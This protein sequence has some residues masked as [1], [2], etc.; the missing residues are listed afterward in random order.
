MLIHSVADLVA[1]IPAALAELRLNIVSQAKDEPSTLRLSCEFEGHKAVFQ[2]A[3]VLTPTAATIEE[4]RQRDSD[5]GQPLLVTVRLSDALA[6]A[7]RE[8]HVNYLDLNGRCRLKTADFLLERHVTNSLP[9][10]R[11]PERD[12]RFF[13]RKSVRL[14]RALLAHPNRVWK[15]TELAEATQLSQGLL[16]RLLNFAKREGWISGERGDWRLEAFDALLDAWA[17]SDRWHKRVQV[18]QYSVL[19][20]DLET[21]ARKLISL[22][23]GELAFTQWFAANRR[24]PYSDTPVISC[25][26]R[27]WLTDPQLQAL[28]AREVTDGGTLWVLVPNDEGVFQCGQDDEGVPLVSDAQIYIDLLPAGLRGPDQAAALRDWRGFCRS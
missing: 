13:S 24:H 27:A 8:R 17:Q 6:Q 2:A 19:E 1:R 5:R 20:S 25:Y 15:Q 26:H 22:T 28:R 3:C 21:L 23:E 4:I 14:T 12:V 7:C 18:K 10:Y 16:S 11:L 9:R